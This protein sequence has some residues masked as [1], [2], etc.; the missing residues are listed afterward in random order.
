MVHTGT[1]SVPR[2]ADQVF[3]LVATPGRFAPQLPDF[4]S[5]T[6]QDATHFMLR[7]VIQVGPMSGHANLAM[8]LS[9]GERPVRVAYRGAAIIAGST[10]QL[11]LEFGL[12]PAGGMTY[13]DWRGE[14]ALGGSLALLAGDLW[15]TLGRQ[16]FERMAERLQVSLCEQPA[17]PGKSN[18]LQNPT[19]TLDFEI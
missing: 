18:I 13:V 3:D 5:V 1:F 2:T 9:D 15:E 16:N 11:N 14:L 17:E 8:E 4:E 19:G 10:L 12:T 7:I 6:M